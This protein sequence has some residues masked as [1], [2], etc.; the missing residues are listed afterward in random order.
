MRKEGKTR[1]KEET[2]RER[3][4]ERNKDKMPVPLQMPMPMPPPI[5][6]SMPMPM[7]MP[8]PMPLQMPMPMPMLLPSLHIPC[9]AL[10]KHIM[11][12][13]IM[14]YR[15]HYQCIYIWCCWLRWAGA[16]CGYPCMRLC[17]HMRVNIPEPPA[18]ANCTSHM[19]GVQFAPVSNWR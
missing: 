3:E 17:S 4:R 14:Y 12:S 8:I 1:K 16:G 9:L 15:I 2:E 5:P 11:K 10:A 7:P 13:T 6:I 19:I 18:S